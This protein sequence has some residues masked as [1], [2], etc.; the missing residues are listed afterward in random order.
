MFIQIA[1]II[2]CSVSELSLTKPVKIFYVFKFSNDSS[3]ASAKE[4]FVIGSFGRADPGTTVKKRPLYL[5]EFWNESVPKCLS[6]CLPELRADKGFSN[7][8]SV[9]GLSGYLR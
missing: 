8:S 6:K 5:S 7:P 9:S 3:W 4:A 2:G 1:S